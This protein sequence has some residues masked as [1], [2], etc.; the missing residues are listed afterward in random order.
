VIRS[1]EQVEVGQPVEV[2]LPDGRLEARVQ[3]KEAN[4]T[5]RAKS[6]E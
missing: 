2:L 3:A 1:I 6:E 5:L 4:D